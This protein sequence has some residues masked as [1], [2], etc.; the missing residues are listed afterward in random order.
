[1]TGSTDGSNEGEHREM[2]RSLRNARIFDDL[3]Y[4][5]LF[6]LFTALAWLIG[7]P[8]FLLFAIAV[9][10]LPLGARAASDLWLIRMQTRL[11]DSTADR[12]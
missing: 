4:I 11:E 1:M 2:M 9:L 8:S 7:L 10:T 5:A 6:P 3:V 12:S